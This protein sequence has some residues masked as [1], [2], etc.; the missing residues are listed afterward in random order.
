MEVFLGISL[1]IF[2]FLIYFLPSFIANHRSHPNENSIFII[3]LFLGCTFI[4]WVISLAWACAR[5]SDE[6]VAKINRKLRKQR[7]KIEKLEAA[8]LAQKPKF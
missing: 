5:I 1:I 4:G 6:D 8:Y 2:L 3:N 7:E